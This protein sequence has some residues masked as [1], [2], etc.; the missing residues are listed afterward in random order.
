MPWAKRKGWVCSGPAS[1]MV[2]KKIGPC[3]VKWCFAKLAGHGQVVGNWLSF[4]GGM[5][6]C[7]K[8][9]RATLRQQAKHGHWLNSNW[10]QVACWSRAICTNQWVGARWQP[11]A[12]KL[13]PL[14]AIKRMLG[15]SLK[16]GSCKLH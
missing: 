3:T 13:S 10:W 2:A 12:A 16:A 15:L 9:C 14:M 6:C 7:R 4:Y 11:T 5:V 1:L 8:A